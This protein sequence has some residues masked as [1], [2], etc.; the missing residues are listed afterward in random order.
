VAE[1]S[2]ELPPF[3]VSGGV[4]LCDSADGRDPAPLLRRAD[5]A[6]YL[7]KRAGRDRIAADELSVT[8][9]RQEMASA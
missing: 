4:A 2:I 8:M 5:A 3:T 7:A 9:Q 6:L 1:P